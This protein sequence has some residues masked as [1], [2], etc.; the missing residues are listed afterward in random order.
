M[1][2]IEDAGPPLT[3][4]RISYFEKELRL[5]LPDQYR[6]FLLRS[7]GGMPAPPGMYA[8]DVE[9]LQGGCADVHVF[10]RIGGSVES[11]ELRWNKETFIE[12]IP[13]TML[14][15]AG[16]SGGSV[17]CLSLREHDHGAV[18]FC[19]LHAVAFDYEATPEFYP[20]APDF[21]T[22]LEKIHPFES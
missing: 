17:F 6:R 3:D 21:D 9:G 11:S 13:D 14:P 19:D 12:R 8:V 20:V 15:I 16:D 10:F 2:A 1:I 4:E 7:N 18:L 5:S 22:F